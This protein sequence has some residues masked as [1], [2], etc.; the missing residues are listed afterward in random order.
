M[1][2]AGIPVGP[3]KIAGL[4]ILAFATALFAAVTRLFGLDTGVVLIAGALGL[5]MLMTAF[6]YVE[7]RRYYRALRHQGRV[8]A[9][10]SERVRRAAELGASRGADLKE[11]V[12][13]IE[14][15]LQSPAQPDEDTLVVLRDRVHRLHSEVESRLTRLE[16]AQQQMHTMLVLLR[17]D[18]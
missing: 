1:R 3:R 13:R 14:K 7:A 6:G 18:Q 16:S 4:V 12:R 5:L 8:L 17:S 2:L 10:E 15:L 9:G 11:R